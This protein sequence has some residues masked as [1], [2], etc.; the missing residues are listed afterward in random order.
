MT[1][2]RT[3]IVSFQHRTEGRAWQVEFCYPLYQVAFGGS[4]GVRKVFSPAPPP[5]KTVRRVNDW[6]VVEAD[7]HR[8]L[9]Q[10]LAKVQRGEG[11][12]AWR[13]RNLVTGQVIMGNG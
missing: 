9:K 6:I 2:A 8:T 1:R 7:K 12:K 10:A 11:A 13:V 4:T 5:F 3:A